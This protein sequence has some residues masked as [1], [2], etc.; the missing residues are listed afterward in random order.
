MLFLRM[1]LPLYSFL[2]VYRIF[3]VYFLCLIAD[4]SICKYILIL[5]FF[6]KKKKK[7]KIFYKG[8]KKK[9]GRIIFK[10]NIN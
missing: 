9:K 10:K 8:K 3:F 1:I 4:S 5:N 7:K 2:P 6:Q